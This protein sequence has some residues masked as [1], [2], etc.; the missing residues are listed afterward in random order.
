MEIDRSD[1]EREAGTA[2]C[3]ERGIPTGRFTGGDSL[4]NEQP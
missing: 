4:V 1:A 2:R 3:D